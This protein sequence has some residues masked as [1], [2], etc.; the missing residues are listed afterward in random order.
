VKAHRHTVELQFA[1]VFVGLALQT[2]G[3]TGVKFLKLFLAVGIAQGKHGVPVIDNGKLLG[4]GPAY[5]LGRRVGLFEFRELFFK[6]MKL[7]QQLIEF[8]IRYFRTVFLVVKLVVIIDLFRES[9]YFFSRLFG[10]HT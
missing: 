5:T 3:D 6:I 4:N 2:F 10:G 1:K 9:L 7:L 8:Q